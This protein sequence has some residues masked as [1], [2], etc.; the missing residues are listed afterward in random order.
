MAVREPIVSGQF[1]PSR[2]V[3]LDSFFKS[4]LKKDSEKKQV[5]ALIVPHAGY[6][7]S[8]K[9]AAYAY[10]YAQIPDTVILLGPN[11]TGRGTPIS[12]YPKGKWKTPYGE[13]AI[14]ET[15]ASS[16]IDRTPF[17]QPDINAH[18]FEHSIEVHLPFIQ[19]LKGNSFKIVPICL[20]DEDK[21]HLSSLASA[22]CDSIKDAKKEAIFIASTDFSH[23]EPAEI[24][25]K[26]DKEC[27]EAIE[28]LDE[29]LLLRI[30]Y[31][32][33]VSMCGYLPVYT[34]IAAS[35]LL[36]AKKGKL[37]KYA[38]SGDVTGDYSEVVGY[39]SIVIE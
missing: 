24:A 10:S 39:A 6:I 7:Y 12:V 29:N 34:V 32:K 33:N 38:T 21:M 5:K 27:I 36:G 15:L 37:L 35:K 19:Y 25:E 11:H 31:E 17:A 13:I 18:M 4:V 9:V 16:I 28:K 8:G 22:I 14:D 26:K 1:Y 23:Y 2:I 30:V 3:D 20:A